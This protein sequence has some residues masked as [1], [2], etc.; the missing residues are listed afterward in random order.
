MNYD[1]RFGTIVYNISKIPQT[2][3]F[4]ST[5]SASL[6]DNITN[7][8]VLDEQTMSK[9]ELLNA[10]KNYIKNSAKES[11][12]EYLK[13]ISEDKGYINKIASNNKKYD[14]FRTEMLERDDVNNLEISELKQLF[15][16]YINFF[17]IDL[18]GSGFYYFSDNK[19]IQG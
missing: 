5:I 12:E 9:Q 6:P 3:S 7:A 18:E 16:K 4:R 13:V 15:S 14:K 11:L 2:A 10:D 17:D 8:I 19:N 1:Y